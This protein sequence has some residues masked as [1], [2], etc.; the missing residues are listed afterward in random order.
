MDATKDVNSWQ[1]KKKFY[2]YG[3]ILEPGTA[4]LESLAEVLL[5][6]GLNFFF[7][8]KLEARDRLRKWR[9]D[10]ERKSEDV[11]DLFISY[12]GSNLS[13]LGDESKLNETIEVLVIMLNVVYF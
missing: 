8:F 1:G 10:N 7:S 5:V 11:V 9:D 4:S 12:L 2:K 13:K 3:T 6:T